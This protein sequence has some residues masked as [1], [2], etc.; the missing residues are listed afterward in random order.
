RSN[1]PGAKSLNDAFSPYAARTKDLAV[2]FNEG[3]RAI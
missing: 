2:T 1:S 3:P